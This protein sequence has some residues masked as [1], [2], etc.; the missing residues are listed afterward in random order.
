MASIRYRIGVD[1]G[2][3][4]CTTGAP[5]TASDV[6]I[7]AA[8]AGATRGGWSLTVKKVLFLLMLLAAF[9]VRAQQGQITLDKQDG[10]TQQWSTD[11][12]VLPGQIVKV[13]A[14]RRVVPS[15]IADTSGVIGVAITTASQAYQTIT[16]STIGD[17]RVFADGSC[18]VGQSIQISSI[19]SGYVNC[20]NSLSSQ[21]LG[22]ALTATS[23][24]GPISAHIVAQGAALVSI[25]GAELSSD[26]TWTNDNRFK[27][28]TPWADVSTF[29]RPRPTA[30]EPSTTA[31][32]TSGLTTCT[33]ASVAG[34]Q[35][36]DGVS[37]RGAGE[38]ET[39]T[40][41]AGPTVTPSIS[42]GGMGLGGG[43]YAS[44]TTV[45]SAIGSSS[46]SYKLIARD[47]AGGYTAAGAATTITNGLAAIGTV[48]CAISSMSRSGT[49][50]TVNFTTACA[51]VVR[52]AMM[53]VFGASSSTFS[54]FFVINTVKSSTQA[55]I[56]SQYNSGAFGYQPG[57]STAN[58]ATGGTATFILSNHLSWTLGAGA[59]QYYVCAE[60]PGDASYKLIGITKPNTT[61]GQD[62]QFDDY[63]SPYNDNQIYP[64]YI[65]NSLCNGSSAQNDPLTT[66]ILNISGRTV[67][68]AAQAINST[69]STTAIFDDAPGFLAAM[70]SVTGG[71]PNFA[72][73]TV[74]IPVTAF[75]FPF[76]INS[77]LKVP[78]KTSIVQV[79]Q[80]VA[81]ETVELDGSITWDGSKSNNGVTQFAYTTT[82]GGASFQSTAVPNIYDAK[83]GDLIE[84][85][86][87]TIPSNS[88]G[89][90][91]ELDDAS[92]VVRQNVQ[93]TTSTGTGY[94]GNAIWYRG[95]GSSNPSKVIIDRCVFTMSPPAGARASW[96]AHFYSPP[97]QNASGQLTGGPS[98]QVW[99]INTD[100]NAFG[101]EVLNNGSNWHFRNDVRQS[102]QE[103]FIW[104]L[105]T[106]SGNVDFDNVFLDTD[107]TGLLSVATVSPI[108]HL[109]VTVNGGNGTASD[110][111]GFVSPITGSPITNLEHWNANDTTF[112]NTSGF[113]TCNVNA[114]ASGVNYGNVRCD[115]DPLLV[116][117]PTGYIFWPMPAP[118]GQ[119]AV[120]A[121]GGSFKSDIFE[122]EI[123]AIDGAGQETVASLA[124]AGV[125]TSA[126]CPRSGNCSVTV[127][128]APVAGA[129]SYNLY[130]CSVR[131][132]VG[133]QCPAFSIMTNYMHIALPVIVV[134]WAGANYAPPTITTAGTSKVN[135][136]G[137][138]GLTH[139]AL[140]RTFSALSKCTATLTGT[141]ATVTDSIVN[142]WGA[143]IGGGGASTVLAFCDGSTWTVYGK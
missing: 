60:R 68:L 62:V 135:S 99:I 26:N 124:T 125:A 54:G 102:G 75:R 92:T 24:S 28:P 133:S 20:T 134:G 90:L 142:T 100:M 19:F 118:T 137:V 52:G 5:C 81:N 88:N 79:G 13:T 109:N 66:T 22:V 67:T 84:N 32:C 93:Y 11:A 69:S 86:S 36:N 50:T 42:S 8:R 121:R 73:G 48:N 33:F 14:N 71:P 27:G 30:P 103:P 37:I 130:A 111:S 139:T 122:F 57:D 129:V 9:P 18:R 29:A 41:P 10:S 46:Y 6:R 47:Q 34:F 131:H 89:G 63:G 3:N 113:G 126:T 31:T 39:M 112:P 23:V 4:V 98:A 43:N 51:Q 107:T 117:G 110:S 123:T 74:L 56:S 2:R 12:P 25:T 59:W 82:G 70:N 35:V 78:A 108:G 95:S 21:S 77:Y 44:M 127:N 76:V 136:T 143:T 105:G 7:S 115:F 96:A 45:P 91:I 1:E 80:L 97:V 119:S 58:S 141:M 132:T 49:V 114:R 53:S 138:W 61:A 64:S 16:V 85:L 17:N 101:F 65:T 104:L 94:L 128:A 15:A 40:T 83:F 72:A 140:P 106:S 38:R 87:L 116:N 55:L 120:V